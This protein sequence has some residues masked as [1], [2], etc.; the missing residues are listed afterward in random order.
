MSAMISFIKTYSL[1]IQDTLYIA[2]CSYLTQHLIHCANLE[3][4][5]LL[6][7]PDNFWIEWL[8]FFIGYVLCYFKVAP[9][10]ISGKGH[11]NQSMQELGT[12]FGVVAVAIS[13]SSVVKKLSIEDRA[14]YMSCTAY[15]M[16]FYF[17]IDSFM[18]HDTFKNRTI[19][20]E[21]QGV[22]RI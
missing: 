18:E 13:L 1:P 11:K 4:C 15:A 17:H 10:L 2:N 5:A 20:L 9:A 16:I 22:E 7:M 19:I 8:C 21:G 14:L 12:I 3:I 6:Q